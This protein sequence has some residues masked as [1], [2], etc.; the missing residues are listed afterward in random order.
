MLRGGKL[1][2]RFHKLAGSK[3]ARV[4]WHFY[5]FLLFVMSC[6]S[7]SSDSGSGFA[8]QALFSDEAYNELL[9]QAGSVVIWPAYQSF[10]SS[11]QSLDQSISSYCEAVDNQSDAATSLAEAQAAWVKAMDDWQYLEAF[12]VGPIAEAAATPRNNIYSWPLISPCGVDREVATRVTSLPASLNRI[13]LDAVAYL[14]FDYDLNHACTDTVEDTQGFNEQSD[15]VKRQQRC[16]YLQLLIP[17]I[18]S[19]ASQLAKAWNPDEENYTETWVSDTSSSPSVKTNELS[20]ALISYLDLNVKD[21]KL[22]IPTGISSNCASSSCPESVE[23]P[24]ANTSL[25]SIAANLRGF[26][27]LFRGSPTETN[28]ASFSGLLKQEDSADLSTQIL[29]SVEFVLSKLSETNQTLAEL[30]EAIDQ[31]ACEASSSESRQV[32]ACAIHADTKVITDELRGDFLEILNLEPPE[33]VAGDN[34]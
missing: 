25:E 18:S 5:T 11:V 14:L 29:D 6:T 32:E 22:A 33:Q 24:F 10:N 9:M 23:H 19:E 26:R 3:K 27:D 15:Q 34:D 21:Q 12:Q 13:G 4:S 31:A 1:F 20:D 7:D 8:E 2:Y 30:T 17:E 28:D 16:N